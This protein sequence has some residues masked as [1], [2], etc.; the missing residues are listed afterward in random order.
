MTWFSV[1]VTDADG[2]FRSIATIQP[3]A[4]Y[5]CAGIADVHSA[6]SQ[7]ALALR[8]NVMGTHSLLDGLSIIGV[9]TGA[10]PCRYGCTAGAGF[11]TIWHFNEYL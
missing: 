1:D 7:S 8:V 2:V 9:D 6:W 4:V 10:N 3:S 11:N 5:H